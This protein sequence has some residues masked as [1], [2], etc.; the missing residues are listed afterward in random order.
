[1]WK[2]EFIERKSGRNKGKLAPHYHLFLFSVPWKFPFRDERGV[3]YHLEKQELADIRADRWL[4]WIEVSGVETIERTTLEPWGGGEGLVLPDEPE[5]RDT[6][7]HWI[8]R[9]WFDVV[10]S[11]D[12]RHHRAGTRVEQLRTIQGAFRYAAK[13]YLGKAV[14]AASLPAQPGRFWGVIGRRNLPR[15]SPD[16]WRLSLRQ[17]FRLLRIIRHYRRAQASNRTRSTRKGG[18]AGTKLYCC[19]DALLPQLRRFLQLRENEIETAPDN[20][21]QLP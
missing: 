17:T 9:A 16:G 11:D 8:S 7:R 5:S 15:A 2:L 19:V 21:G 4:E 20:P 3:H 10:G 6:L 14:D 1:M 13:S 18:L 12:L